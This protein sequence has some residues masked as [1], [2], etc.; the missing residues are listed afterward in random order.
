MQD[1]YTHIRSQRLPARRL[2]LR[3]LGVLVRGAEVNLAG[4]HRG[5]LRGGARSSRGGG[6]E[7]GRCD[8]D[9]AMGSYHFLAGWR[10][11]VLSSGVATLCAP[12]E[13]VDGVCSNPVLSCR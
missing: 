13:A 5:A 3:V 11:S 9:G 2:L 12:A 4:V 10:S 8:G 7:E 1:G 6:R